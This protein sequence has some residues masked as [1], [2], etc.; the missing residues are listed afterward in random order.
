[1]NVVDSLLCFRPGKGDPLDLIICSS[2]P[3]ED[4]IVT[5]S[6]SLTTGYTGT[7]DPYYST[8]S[9]SSSLPKRMGK[10]D[11]GVGSTLT[12]G[13][14]SV[15]LEYESTSL[16]D[17]VSNKSCT[18][19]SKRSPPAWYQRPDSINTSE[20][21]QQVMEMVFYANNPNEP[22]DCHSRLSETLFY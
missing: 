9:F 12:G 7:F 10:L 19:S 3:T 8:G 17:G 15:F 21:K 2:P 20:I 22:F 6:E 11:R 18:S 5:S 1:M 4:T 16:G 14:S 13:S